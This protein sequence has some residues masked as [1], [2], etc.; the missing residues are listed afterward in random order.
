MFVFGLLVVL[1]MICW[2][3]GPVAAQSLFCPA[4]QTFEN[5]F[6]VNPTKGPAVPPCPAGWGPVSFGPQ[7]ACVGLG[8]S[9]AQSQ[10]LATT[11]QSNIQ[12][13]NSSTL[14]IASAR[15]ADASQPCPTG[16][17]S[18]NGACQ[19]ISSG[20]GLNYAA[21]QDATRQTC[22]LGEWSSRL[23]RLRQFNRRFGRNSQVISKSELKPRAA[24]RRA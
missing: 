2:P 18:I 21:E 3:S 11:M 1:Q 7:M 4:G 23:Y 14:E 8:N 12:E 24:Q 6:C 9:A 10:T 19:P 16:Y 20:N 5:G 22:R 15:R 17:Q 13:L